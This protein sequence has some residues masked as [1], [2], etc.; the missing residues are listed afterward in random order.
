VG[1][2]RLD[3]VD[4]PPLRRDGDDSGLVMRFAV[5]PSGVGPVMGFS[6][7][8]FFPVVLESQVADQS[9]DSVTSPAGEPIR[10]ANARSGS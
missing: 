9:E 3:S 2:K 8:D 4:G 6:S 7:D 10:S 5:G 1:K